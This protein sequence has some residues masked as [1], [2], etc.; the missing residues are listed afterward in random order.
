MKTIVITGASSG[1]GA[2]MARIYA[3]RGDRVAL[4]A[5]RGEMLAENVKAIRASG[6]TAMDVI[7]DVADRQSVADAVARVRLEWGEIDLAVA[8]AG[9]SRTIKL[10][11]FDAGEAEMIMRTNVFGMFYL[12]E[13][14]VPQ[15]IARKEGHFAGIASLAGLRVL[16][17]AS[18]YSASKAAMQNFLE[19]AR[20][21]LARHGVAVTTINP[22]FIATEMTARHKF[23]M[24]FLLE[25]DPASQVIVDA[26]DAKKREL[27]FPLPTATLMKVTRA[28]PN[29]VFDRALKLTPKP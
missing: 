26:L 28:L 18:V 17:G 1:I 19:G 6:G 29:F 2:S 14:I 25:C 13:A 3:K 9:V 7:C 21:E 11:E 27:N 16:P 8:N 12:F 20:L 24:P 15:M 5:R 10:A 23:K 22:G 4:L